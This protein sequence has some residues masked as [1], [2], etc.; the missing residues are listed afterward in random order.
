MEEA[1]HIRIM[2][3]YCDKWKRNIF[4][5]IFPFLLPLSDVGEY[6]GEKIVYCPWCGE[7]LNEPD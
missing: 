4:K 6:S 5:L 1:I 2:E 3:C 7:K